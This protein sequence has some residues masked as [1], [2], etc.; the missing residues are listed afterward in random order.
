MALD[1]G[2]FLAG[3]DRRDLETMLLSYKIREG[4]DPERVTDEVDEYFCGAYPSRCREDNNVTPQLSPKVHLAAKVAAYVA[5]AIRIDAQKSGIPRVDPAE[6]LRR[7]DICRGCPFNQ[8]WEASCT[9]CEESIKVA[10]GKMVKKGPQIPDKGLHGCTAFGTWLP[11]AVR[12]K[13]THFDARAPGHCWRKQP[14]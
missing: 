1:D 14:S 2:T 4:L 9:L 11:L 5:K 10:G 3:R 6:A 7:A 8:Q 13:W 12:T